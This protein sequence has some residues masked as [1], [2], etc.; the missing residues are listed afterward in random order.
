MSGEGGMPVALTGNPSPRLRGGRPPIDLTHI[1][2]A[3]FLAALLVLAL[4][5]SCGGGGDRVTQTS[6]KTDSP[7]PSASQAMAGFEVVSQPANGFVM[8][9]PSGWKDVTAEATKAM[10]MAMLVMVAPTPE[11]GA[12][13]PEAITV[14]VGSVPYDYTP[15]TFASQ[16]K[17]D[18]SITSAQVESL[19]AGKFAHLQM[20]G[21]TGSGRHIFAIPHRGRMYSIIFESPSPDEAWNAQAS[22]V[23]EGF[24]LV[25]DAQLAD[26]GCSEALKT[27]AAS[28]GGTLDLDALGLSAPKTC[29]SFAVFRETA[30]RELGEVGG[31]SVY[32]FMARS[33]KYADASFGIKETNLCKELIARS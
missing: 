32:D 14:L 6:S 24:H 11:T 29:G 10:P 9:V 21:P 23:V 27:F 25:P 16:A 13:S 3:T 20:S 19:P 26:P 22:A 2:H 28:A 7:Q 4:T 1:K 12:K 5:T 33:C 8:S 15:E 17:Q 30:L 18:L 31:Q